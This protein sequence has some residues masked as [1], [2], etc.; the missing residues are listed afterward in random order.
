L[1]DFYNVSAAP[2]IRSPISTKSIMQDVVIALIPASLF[3]IFNF[4]LRAVLVILSTVLACV[5]TEYTYCKLMKKP[6]TPG[7]YS[8]V[9]TGLL[10]ALNLPVS[11][12]IW[13]AVLGGVF[14][15][16]IVKM[17]YGGLG[18]NFMNPAL[19]ARVFLFI[20][21]PARMSSFALERINSPG[22]K[23]FLRDGALVLDGVSGATPLGQ[24]KAGEGVDL[25]KMFVGNIG[26]T[27]G[28]TSAL[29]LLLG[30]AYLVYRKVISLRIPLSYIISFAVFALLF[31]GNGFDVNYLLGQIL[32]GGL[33]IGAFY[34]AT[35]YVTSPSTHKGQ[36]VFGIF[37]GIMTG[38]FRIIGSGVEG[39]SYA[40]ILGNLLVPMINMFTRPKTFGKERVKNGYNKGKKS[41]ILKDALSLT[42]ITIVCSFALAFV[43]EITKDPIKAQEDAKKNAGYIVVYPDAKELA[44][45]EELVEL[46]A[47]VDLSTL[48]SEFAGVTIDDVIQALD[49]D[50]N[51]MGYI[52]KSNTR[53][54]SSTISVAT[55]YSLDGVVQGI[56]LLSI[57]DT[58]GYG[59]ELT[60]DEFKDRFK[61]VE[62]DHFV[63]TRDNASN[64]NDIDVYSGSTTST[65]AV[66]KAVNAGI[67]FLIENAKDLG[68]GA[69]E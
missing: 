31:G 38:I 8:D 35:D 22:V 13:M 51:K 17:L 55:G 45:D 60:N 66:V 50:G 46:A 42:I 36:I 16:L 21:F 11:I 68:G 49:S 67:G 47:E 39:V 44:T 2:H 32:G 19:A 6:I 41:T 1:S 57:G 43:Y 15:I 26:G 69:N 7:D 65:S 34:M 18:Q 14:A 48:D 62:T 27:I 24:L 64:D 3:G 53:G 28:E 52:V 30:A 59:M 40:I 29:A 9:V 58:V 63:L 5:I 25:F 23:D 37:L 61:G 33:I 12:P 10:L 4:G 54:Y 56:E 20:S